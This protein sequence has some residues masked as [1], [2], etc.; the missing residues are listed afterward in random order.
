MSR[1][2]SELR[3][4]GQKRLVSER[5]LIVCEGEKTEPNYLRELIQALGINPQS[6]DCRIIDS[7]EHGAGSAPITIYRK[8]VVEFELD[9]D[10]DRVYCV[11]DR[12]AHSTYQ[13]AC[14][15]I[16]NK[17]LIKY[18]D[19]ND[20]EFIA[21]FKAVTSDPRFE[22]WLLLHFEKTTKSFKKAGDVEALLRM[23]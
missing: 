3:R 4:G 11:F 13:A 2:P 15:N 22:Y 7:S 14:Q 18:T 10:F 21:Q 1:K 17:K 8:A 5:I 12:D 16:R 19:E 20:K 6:A 23:S 9:K